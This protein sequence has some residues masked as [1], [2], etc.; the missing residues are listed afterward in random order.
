MSKFDKIKKIFGSV[1]NIGEKKKS[2]I[3]AKNKH[4]NF[5]Y[6]NQLINSGQ[7]EITLEYDIILDKMEEEQFGS[8]IELKGIDLTIDGNGHVIDACG[9]AKIF[10]INEY[11]NITLKNITLK[12]GNVIEDKS[13]W[14]GGAITNWGELVLD[15]VKLENNESYG[16]AGAIY[17][18][19]K[20]M[21][22]DATL[23]NNHAGR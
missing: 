2:I 7:K 13:I 18:S 5:E 1:G 10:S 23:E 22:N 16:E 8:G 21:L 12:N 14:G 9:K 6:L 4:C 3:K 15:S 20:I 11:S 17:N 19:G